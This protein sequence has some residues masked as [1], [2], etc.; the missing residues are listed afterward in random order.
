MDLSDIYVR[1]KDKLD[2]RIRNL[3]QRYKIIEND[4]LVLRQRLAV[5]EDKF[6]PQ[7]YDT[8]IALCTPDNIPDNTEHISGTVNFVKERKTRAKRKVTTA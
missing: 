1:E 2:A 3:E 4:N 8:D 5:V 6:R 7:P